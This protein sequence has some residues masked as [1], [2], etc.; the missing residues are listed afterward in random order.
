[1]NSETADTAGAPGA[2]LRQAQGRLAILRADPARMTAVRDSWRALWTSRLLVWTAGVGTVLALGFGPT[3]GA[4]N[5]PG[6]TRGFGSLG[7][8]LAAPAA[9][10]DSAWYLVIARFGYRPD[11][12]HYTAPRTAFFPLYPLGLKAISWLG[13]PPVLAGVLLSI[14]A[15][16]L[17]LYGIHRLTTL[18]LGARGVA[19]PAEAARLA[20]LLTAFG[21]MAFFFSAVY[22]ESLFLALSVGL[23][24]S[25]R[26]G[27]WALV[28]VLGALAAATRSAGIVLLLPALMLYLYGPRL[29][30]PPDFVRSPARRLL[31]VY[32]LRRNVLWIAL[33]PAGVA[34][35]GLGL[36]LGGGDAFAPLHAQDVWGRH[37]AGPYLGIW[38]GLKA[39]FEGARQLL[40]FQRQTIYFKQGEGSPT[41]AAAHNL[42]LFAFLLL[43]IPLFV[44]A[45]RRLPLAYFAYAVAA[46]ALPLSYPVSSQP[47]MSLPRF[48]IVLFPLT[49][50]GGAWLAEHPRAVRPLLAGSAVLMA[51]FLAQFA[52]WHWVA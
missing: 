28:G 46:L 35:Y 37:F 50:A 8:V 38:D 12:G 18:E 36:A 24:W 48:P 47:L 5:P 27:R 10:W 9:R 52:T 4:F 7:D 25:A 2:G 29:D 13:A 16:G 23:F 19:R 26:S 40:S 1:M 39:A 15:L 43:A 51:F 31:P 3:R 49:I 32:R 44:A 42:T 34:F 20:V 45:L 33:L 6:V 41:V 11:L 17:G 21:P 14:A 22:S 30:R